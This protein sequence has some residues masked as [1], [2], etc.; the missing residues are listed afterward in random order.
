MTSLTAGGEKN[1]KGQ[2]AKEAKKLFFLE[3]PEPPKIP[4]NGIYHNALYVALVMKPRKKVFR[5][6]AL[7][8]FSLLKKPVFQSL[9]QIFR[10]LVVFRKRPTTLNR[11]FS[12]FLQSVCGCKF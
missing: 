11:P 1:G 5:E 8:V 6:V 7:R 10:S 9:T 2:K 4:S 12:P 3:I